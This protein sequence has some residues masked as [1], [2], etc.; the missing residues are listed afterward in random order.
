MNINYH[1][2]LHFLL[3]T[4]LMMA[5]LRGVLADHC[6]MAGMGDMDMSEMMSHDMS[7]S[8][9]DDSMQ[10]DINEYNCCEDISA[11]CSDACDIGVNVSLLLQHTQYLPVYNNSFSLNSLSYKTLFRELTPPS[12]PPA[13]LHS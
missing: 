6:D 4:F 1:K 12:R 2:L 3:I 9:I 10:S 5:P 11:N 13:S 7:E 8:M